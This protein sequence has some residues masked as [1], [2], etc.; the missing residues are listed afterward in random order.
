MFHQIKNTFKLGKEYPKFCDEVKK[1]EE[2]LKVAQK[3]S[4]DL[5]EALKE[6]KWIANTT[7]CLLQQV[8]GHIKPD[9]KV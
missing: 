8:K 3:L 1:L 2:N 6:I 5:T 9:E 4:E 7:R